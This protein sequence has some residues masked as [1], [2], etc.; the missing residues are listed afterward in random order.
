LNYQFKYKDN[1]LSEEH[2]KQICRFQDA[3]YVKGEYQRLQGYIQFKIWHK[4][5]MDKRDT[6]SKKLSSSTELFEL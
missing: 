5:A 6:E 1:G 2:I 3:P 4:K